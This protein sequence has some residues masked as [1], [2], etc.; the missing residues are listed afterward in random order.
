M[1][2]RQKD[3]TPTEKGLGEAR[4]EEL[5][6]TI[7]LFVLRRTKDINE[8]YLP[9]KTEMVLF[10]K[11]S[12]LQLRLYKR[13]LA[14]RFVRN[15]VTAVH[16]GTQHLV[17]ISLLKQLC[18]SPMLLAAATEASGGEEAAVDMFQ[19]AREELPADADDAIDTTLNGKMHVLRV[20]L[21][22]L[23]AAPEKERVLVVSNST[24]C[25]DRLQALCDHH[26]WPTL[27][28]Q[29]STPTSKRLEMVNRFNARRHDDF[30]FLM[31]GLQHQYWNGSG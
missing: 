25:L 8:R 11:P 19:S 18:N 31:V 24:K 3:A 9:L 6:K 15:C 16:G 17:I 30:V 2:S 12:E 5:N 27:R 28:L 26:G 14:T 20:L 23:R 10:C 1:R 21:E 4:S 13:I 22:R 29:G 7:H